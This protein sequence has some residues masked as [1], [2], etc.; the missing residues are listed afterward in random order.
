MSDP[1]LTIVTVCRNALDD[2]QR[3]VTSVKAQTFSDYEYLIVDGG[4]TDGSAEWLDTQEGIKWISEP[5]KGIYDAM[6]KGVQMAAGEWII[7][8][9]AGD[10]FYTPEVLQQVVP[11]L[12]DPHGLVYGDISKERKG[13]EVIKRAE[14]PHNAHRMI[15]CHQALFT[16]TTLLK[17]TPFDTSYRLSADFKFFKQMYLRAV[18]MRHISVV[19]ARFDT[20]G[21]SN[22]HRTEGL[23][24]NIRIIQETDTR[25][26][27]RFGFILRLRFTIL[28]SKLRHIR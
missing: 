20:R 5:D 28:W 27:E 3:T 23:R 22:T 13:H 26:W 1:K 25:S 8:M 6:N 11:F 16:R 12:K 17:D 24:E 10:T 7:F 9:N 21:E 18:P 14:K 4:S 2:L 19:I 15:C